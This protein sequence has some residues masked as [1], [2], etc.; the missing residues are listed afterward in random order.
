MNFIREDT[1]NLDVTLQKIDLIKKNPDF[2]LMVKSDL[3]GHEQGQGRRVFYR[4]KAPR[5]SN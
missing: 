2:L 1:D 5:V 3:Q 4:K